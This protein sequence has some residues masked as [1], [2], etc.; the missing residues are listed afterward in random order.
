MANRSNS[1][2]NRS[3][4]QGLSVIEGKH[5]QASSDTHQSI[6]S[7][8]KHYKDRSE[9]RRRTSSLAQNDQIRSIIAKTVEE[10][11]KKN[12]DNEYTVQSAEDILNKVLADAKESG[13]SADRIFSILSSSTISEDGVSG[14]KIPKDVFIDG[15]R[16][17]S[18]GVHTWKKDDLNFIADRFDINDDG[19]ISLE[20]FQ[21]YCY[22]EV[23]SLAWKA[24]RQRKEAAQT[25]E[26]SDSEDASFNLKEIKYP[27]GP[28]CYKLSKL[29]WKINLSVEISLRYCKELD[30][31][32]IQTHSISTKQDFKTLY[33]KKSNC[34]IDKD[35]L[36]KALA[37]A[38]QEKDDRSPD[39]IAWSHYS[40]Y[41]VVR[42]HIAKDEN[43]TTGFSPSLMKLHGDGE[44]RLEIDQPHNMSAP[45]RKYRLSDKT[46]S[47]E[48]EFNRKVRSFEK[49][50]RSARTSRQTAEG[51]I[52]SA[53]NSQNTAEGD[54]GLSDII[55]QAL[56]E[57]KF[58]L[59][60][61]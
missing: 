6:N 35:A 16:K 61:S 51:F 3:T 25:E 29:F 23:P 8:F 17:L 4:F 21:H 49:E 15:L 46:K 53:R 54:G 45:A 9:R 13:Y 14:D 60:E 44:T 52:R 48:D 31:I 5:R 34:A 24:E 2:F 33:V 30:V 1:R 19:Y 7:D 43:D 38:S 32:S 42:L 59:G 47:L 28:E 39:E 10:L 20:E 50:S 22:H 26:K 27:P 55:R 36:D 41:L 18:R 57:V 58:E 11:S 12:D 56:D 37:V 40:N